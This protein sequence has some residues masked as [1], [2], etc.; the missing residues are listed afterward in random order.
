M[1]CA[2]I[3]SY[4]LLQ[5]QPFILDCDASNVGIGAVLSQ[6]QNGEE[7]VICYYSKCLSRSERQYCTTRKELLAVVLAVKN[8]HH[9]LFGQNFT[10]RTDHGSLQWLM[11][12]KNC[13]GQIARWIE[14]LSAYTFTVVHRSGRVHNNADSLSRRPCYN[15]SCKFCE[16][17][18]KRYSPELLINVLENVR[19][20]NAVKSAS[21]EGKGLSDSKVTLNDISDQEHTQSALFYENQDKNPEFIGPFNTDDIFSGRSVHTTTC[22][23]PGVASVLSKE[24]TLGMTQIGVPHSSQTKVCA[25]VDAEAH[26]INND[27]RHMEYCSCKKTADSTEDWW[28]HFGD[29]S[30][31]GRLFETEDFSEELHVA[32]AGMATSTK[33]ARDDK[34]RCPCEL[35]SVMID[36]NV[37]DLDSLHN[38]RNCGHS[39]CNR[40]LCLTIGQHLGES[41]QSPAS[42][43]KPEECLDITQEN[44]RIQQGN[45]TTLKLL[46]EWKR[47]NEKPS[48]SVVAPYCK[49]LKAYWHEWDTIELRDN[50]LYKRREKDVCN[51]AEYLFLVPAILRKE[52]FRQ[53]HEYITAGHLGRRK[54]YDKIKKRFYWCNMYKDVSYWCRICSTCGSRKMP[55]RH[56]K[57][58][59]QQYN[60]GYPMERIGV[61]ICGP[62]PISK[63]GN[64]Y[65]MVVS[66]Y[67]TK[68]VDAIPLKTQEAKNVASKLVNRFISIF[69]VPLQL[70]TD[71]GTNFEAKVFQEVCM[72]LGINKTRTSIRRPQSDGL[73]ERANRSIQNMIASYISDK[74]DDW[75]EHIPLLMMAYRSSIHETTGVSPAL[76]MLGRELTLPIDLTLGRPIREDRLCSTEH[77]Y[78]L[79]QKL[80]DVHDFARKQLNI[81]SESMKR[82][83]DVKVHKNPYKLGDAV[84]YFSP[85]RKVGF[86]PKL[87]RPWKGPMVV[88]EILNDVLFRIQ[89]GP[90]A[91][92]I[93]VVNETLFGK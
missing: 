40:E 38:D 57:A 69:G 65:L 68:W 74:Q 58:P 2:P 86:N 79:E 90:R 80:L 44:I 35:E 29:E 39:T 77:A 41:H 17:Y 20:T 50:V 27:G 92:P 34:P 31:I 83:Y 70:H 56:A 55:Y 76:M 49:E 61:D 22:L 78:Q 73:V 45:D 63:K 11:R 88:V 13:E 12:F 43:E 89:S 37:P 6:L 36:T 21:E 75:D 64:K 46:L 25:G 93:V 85:K 33:G 42:C 67:F 15:N 52:V 19:E 14:T 71:L 53:L 91:K 51:D 84:W 5:G 59:M 30:L 1:T 62:Y 28:D 60:V 81:S 87:Q 66:C 4:P 3:L 8:F 54:T 10:V 47:I 48:W 24:M 23:E 18:E 16:R 9:Y 82:R 26:K 32:H 7:K 72:L